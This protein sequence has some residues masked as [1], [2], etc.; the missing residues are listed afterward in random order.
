MTREFKACCSPWRDFGIAAAAYALPNAA[1]SVESWVAETS[2]GSEVAAKIRRRGNE[3]LYRAEGRS[4]GD[5]AA[6]V[7]SRLIVDAEIDPVNVDV[8]CVASSMATSAPAAPESLA[9]NLARQFKFRAATAFSLSQL[10]CT[11]L[12]GAVHFLC[13][14]AAARPRI[15]NMLIVTSDVMHGEAYRNRHLLDLQSDGAAAILISRGCE[16][17][18]FGSIVVETMMGHHMGFDC[19]PELV[20][21]GRALFPKKIGDV[22]RRALESSDHPIDSYVA[23]IPTNT[24]APMWQSYSSF[25]GRT[26]EFVYTKN[27]GLK[28][29]ACCTDAIANLVDADLLDL[30]PERSVIG[31][32]LSSTAVF[33][34]FT[35]H[36]VQATSGGSLNETENLRRKT[37]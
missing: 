30:K 18:R 12:I 13:R 9:V 10:N 11:S 36:G 25:F 21:R 23:L 32:T 4:V 8:V 24:N 34:A 3:Y 35:L 37:S 28:A 31:V 7:V 5:L 2:Q 14:Y 27:V 15:R 6:E 29:H 22:I 33:G 19:A 20:F 26:E 17:N 1:V 16:R